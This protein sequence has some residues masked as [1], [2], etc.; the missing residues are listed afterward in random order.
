MLVTENSGVGEVSLCPSAWLLKN[1]SE[2]INC[3]C[4]AD[5]SGL[6]LAKIFKINPCILSIL[7]HT[8]VPFLSTVRSSLASFL[9]DLWFLC[10]H[11]SSQHSLCLEILPRYQAVSILLTMT[12]THFHSVQ[13]DHSTASWNQSP[14]CTQGG[15]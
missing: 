7:Y 8:V 13:E 2:T 9:S 3:K 11:P 5:S 6:L 10:L 14:L 15:Q 4:S 12:A 1:H